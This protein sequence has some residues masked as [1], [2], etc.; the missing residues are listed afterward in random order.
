M[1]VIDT[2]EPD[3]ILL[4]EPYEYQNRSVWIENKYRIFTAGKGKHRAALI[5]INGKIDAML[6]AKLSNEDKILLEI[7]HK[8]WNNLQPACTE[9]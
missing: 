8:S 4:Q 7:I 6:I 2:E 9:I 1:K 3:F 5:I